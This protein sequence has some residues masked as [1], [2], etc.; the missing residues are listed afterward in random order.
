MDVYGL[1]HMHNMTAIL[2]ESPDLNY[3]DG[4]AAI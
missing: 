2:S 4:T 3:C 1:Y